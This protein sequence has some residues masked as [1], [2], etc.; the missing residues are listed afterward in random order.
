M[1][2]C[3]L[4]GIRCQ[5]WDLGGGGDL[6]KL[7]PKYYKES[8]AV[9]YVIDALELQNERKISKL[10]ETFSRTIKRKTMNYSIALVFL[11]EFV[12]NEDIEGVPVAV[13]SNKQDLITDLEENLIRVKETF[14]PLMERIEA[15]ESKVFGVSA[16]TGY[17][18][19]KIIDHFCSHYFVGKGLWRL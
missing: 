4:K 11:G 13:L 8:H 3:D 12:A 17:K 1:S 18:I 15:R 19:G 2:K 7:W 14:N 6:P 16:L 5:F 10:K 9:F